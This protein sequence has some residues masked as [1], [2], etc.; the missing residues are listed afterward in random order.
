MIRID[1]SN[2]AVDKLRDML[3]TADDERLAARIYCV[4]G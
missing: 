3:E 4:P 2:D 1:I